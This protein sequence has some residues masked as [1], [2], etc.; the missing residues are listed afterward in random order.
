MNGV[1][2]VAILFRVLGADFAR[3]MSQQMRPEEVSRVGEAMVRFEQTPP[4]DETVQSILEEFRSM[5]TDGGLFA[6]VNET[7]NE[8]FTAKFGNDKGPE[9]L[10]EVRVNA[11]V[12]SPFKGLQGVPFTDL[13]RILREEHPQVQAAV[14]ANIGPELAAGVLGVMDQEER[15]GM[16]RRIATMRTPPPRVLRDIA[17]MFIEKTSKLPRFQDYDVSGPEPGIKTAADILNAA[18]GD[19]NEGLLER[20]EEEGPELVEQIRETMFTFND[21][22]AVDKLSMQKILGGID[23]KLLAM[24]L[25]A[26]PE[27][28]TKAIFDAV[29]QRTKDMIIEEKEL[30]GAVPLIEV[31]NAQREI[32][33]T[34]RGLIESGELSI[35]TG[36]AGAQLVE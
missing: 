29:S 16:L 34:I 20:L 23:T 35:N 28:V 6:N 14:L 33:Q 19:T 32:M 8:I 31:Q 5:M 24:S 13:S 25:K 9:I 22:T 17:D 4:D 2:K 27:D 3:P 7:L 36:G 30:L 10:E 12:E 26:C 15:A 18:S 1:E 21:L 11:Q